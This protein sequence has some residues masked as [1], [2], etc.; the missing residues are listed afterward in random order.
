MNTENTNENEA[1]PDCR[2]RTSEDFNKFSDL[3]DRNF[4][5]LSQARTELGKIQQQTEQIENQKIEFI[6]KYSPAVEEVAKL[7][8][9]ED[10]K[11]Q[12]NKGQSAAEAF[13]VQ[14]ADFDKSAK[15]AI[16]DTSRM[17]GGQASDTILIDKSNENKET[18]DD[19]SDKSN[20]I[21]DFAELEIKPAVLKYLEIIY[22]E[23]QTTKI[24][25]DGLVE[26]GFPDIKDIYERVRSVLRYYHRKAIIEKD[27]INWG[28]GKPPAGAGGNINSNSVEVEKTPGIPESNEAVE[29]ETKTLAKYC[30]IILKESGQPWLHVDQFIVIL[31]NHFGIVKDKN[32]VS[33]TLRQKANAGKDFKFWGKNRFGLL[34]GD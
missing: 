7:F 23:K 22:P 10:D 13:K 33:S 9:I 14:G 2:K 4:V 11:T 5:I 17:G 30:K 34:E 20:E 31:N 6:N 25:C 27:G 18:E 21:I 8:K 3:I 19:K 24:I 12:T 29:D 32:N 1:L 15:S 28:L 16:A 26:K